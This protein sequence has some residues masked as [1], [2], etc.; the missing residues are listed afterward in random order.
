M[1]LALFRLV[2]TNRSIFFALLV[3]M[4]ANSYIGAVALSTQIILA[5]ATTNST[6]E[7]LNP[8]LTN[9]VAQAPGG[10]TL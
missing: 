3:M 1:R 4:V 2:R 9:I 5:H 7:S 8:Q 10:P 6:P